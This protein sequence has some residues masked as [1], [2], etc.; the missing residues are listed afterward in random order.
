MS[1]NLA[2]AD[3]LAE[4]VRDDVAVVLNLRHLAEQQAPHLFRGSS[5]EIWT[6]VDGTRTVEKIADELAEAYEAPRDVVAVDVKAFVAQL[7][8]L[9]LVLE[10]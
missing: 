1:E 8:E 9:G 6:R 3:G 10:G 4:I 7:V 2:R 5:F